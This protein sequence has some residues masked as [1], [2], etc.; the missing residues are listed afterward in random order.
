M[1]Q[2]NNE[3]LL[4]GTNKGGGVTKNTNRRTPFSVSGDPPTPVVSTKLPTRLGTIGTS[5]AGDLE[6]NATLLREIHGLQELRL[7]FLVIV[8]CRA[9]NLRGKEGGTRKHVDTVQRC[10][11]EWSGSCLCARGGVSRNVTRTD[12][13]VTFQVGDDH[14][15]RGTE[16]R[17]SK[18]FPPKPTRQR[19]RA[20][21]NPCSWCAGRESWTDMSADVWLRKAD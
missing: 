7:Q 9:N 12:I 15:F 21:E 8:K 10:L 13:D 6:Q 11:V 16:S 3:I 19:I 14:F 20:K 17:R 4:T 1:A 2:W 5:L 18:T